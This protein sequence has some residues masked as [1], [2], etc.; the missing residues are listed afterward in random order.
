M[1]GDRISRRAVVPALAAGAGALAVGAPL[2]AAAPKLRRVALTAGPCR[3]WPGHTLAVDVFVPPVS[4]G[5]Q[6][7]AQF[8]LVLQLADGTQIVSHDFEVLPGKGGK[9]EVG[10]LQDGQ[11][12]V[13]NVPVPGVIFLVVIA[14]IAILIGLLLPAVQKVRASSTSFVPGVTAGEQN[15]D[16]FLEFAEQG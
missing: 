6:T 16:Y 5:P 13:N 7:P 2:Q 3:L 15:V 12:V 8:Q 1:A 14:I 4:R 9:V 11:L 10:L